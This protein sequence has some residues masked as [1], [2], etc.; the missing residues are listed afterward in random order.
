[1]KLLYGRRQSVVDHKFVVG[2]EFR[3]AQD[4]SREVP[5]CPLVHLRIDA[6]G[7]MVYWDLVENLNMRKYLLVDDITDCRLLEWPKQSKRAGM[8]KALR[9]VANKDFSNHLFYTFAHDNEEVLETWS[10]FIFKWVYSQ[11]KQYHSP[12][13]YL[14]KLAAPGAHATSSQQIYVNAYP[15]SV[16]DENDAISKAGY[17]SH[18]NI[19]NS[20]HVTNTHFDIVEDYLEKVKRPELM[21]LF[22]QLTKGKGALGVEEFKRF[23][24]T[25]QRDS[26]LNE[27][28]HPKKTLHEIR[29]IINQIEPGK[30]ALSFCGFATYMLSDV[31]LDNREFRLKIGTMHHAISHYYINSSHN[32]YLNGNQIQ[33]AKALPGN[34]CQ[35]CESD[36]EMYRQTL[37]AGCRC[38]ELDCWDGVNGEPV[39]THGP[40]ALQKINVLPFREV[41]EAIMESAFKTS[42]Y[43]VV[44]SIENHCGPLQQRIMASCFKD[45]FGECLQKEPLP[46]HP[47]QPGVCLPSPLL[48]KRKILLKGSKSNHASRQS[49]TRRLNAAALQRR[50]RSFCETYTSIGSSVIKKS[51]ANILGTEPREHP[52][53]YDSVNARERSAERLLNQCELD[54]EE[55]RRLR[56]Q[57][58]TMKYETVEETRH[59]LS[60]LINYF[61]TTKKPNLEDPD[62]CMH[63]GSE[64][65]IDRLI[66]SNSTQLIQHT[67]G[68]I[69]RVYPDISRIC[70]SNFI[71]MYFWTAGCQ[72]IALNFQTNGLPMQMNQTLFE[73]NGHSGYVLKPSCLRQRQNKISVH[74]GNILVANR[75]EV[76]IISA[77]FICLMSPKRSNNWVSSVAL[78]LYDLPGDTVRDKFITAEVT[79]DG[80]NTFYPKN[81]FVFE[82]IIKPEHA[83]LHIRLLD[84]NK[85]ELGQR[86]LPI[87]KIQP[88]YRHII[89][90]NR[91]NRADGPATVYAKFKVEVYVP[92][93]QEELRRHYV[94]PL[95][96][97]RE[98]EEIR[99]SFA[100]PMR[101]SKTR[102][103][104]SK[105]D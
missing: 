36:V 105:E 80:Y 61:Q 96:Y 44:L 73:E 69:L 37:L 74:D 82:K 85:E 79:G 18:E 46:E 5:G 55:L 51:A 33:A 103:T 13:S 91:A 50:A 90:R 22:N 99:Q 84:E 19:L 71:P 101:L 62:Y 78:D 76:E 45:V 87:H 93:C 97:L 11:R 75:L 98:Q 16:V 52:E 39:I 57:Y 67:T 17:D 72:M 32:T 42:E 29:K 58:D 64:H 23:I 41:C 47:L 94:D 54:S 6:D 65:K 31:D 4:R 86:F 21:E 66:T 8:G 24:N 12:L 60:D 28:I 30:T 1:M 34:Q 77:Q 63:S 92:R 83:M 81:K 15:K 88:G 53:E 40:I 56:E 48:L 89:M 9:I 68:H 20:F 3:F 70:S 10:S 2:E 25:T 7:F 102:K 38:I 26:R 14:Q 59:E 104:I 49:S 100:N 35:I 43:P 27:E 95:K